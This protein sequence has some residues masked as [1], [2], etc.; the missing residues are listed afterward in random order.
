M[1][2]NCL[3]DICIIRYFSFLIRRVLEVLI[4]T[5]IVLGLLQQWI[6]P[7]VMNSLIPFSEMHLFKGLGRLLKLAVGQIPCPVF[8]FES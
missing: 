5:Q 6:F 2:T 4:G 1:N 7:S 8:S 3:G